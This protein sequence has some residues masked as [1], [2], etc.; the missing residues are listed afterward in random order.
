MALKSNQDKARHPISDRVRGFTYM[1][2]KR[3][4][5]VV[6][7]KRA[8]LVCFWYWSVRSSSS[9]KST[10]IGTRVTLS[11][12]AVTKFTGRLHKILKISSFHYEHNFFPI[13]KIAIKV[14]EAGHSRKEYYWIFSSCWN[15]YSLNKQWKIWWF[16]E[17][18]TKLWFFSM[19]LWK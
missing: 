8:K 18:L 5:T 15:F 7:F 3:S 19:M 11:L 16:N 2:M 4:K 10:N 12:R 6:S 14:P 13:T 17:L 9:I 1:S